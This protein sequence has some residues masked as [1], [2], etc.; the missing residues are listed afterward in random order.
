MLDSWSLRLN[1]CFPF[2]AQSR[3]AASSTTRDLPTEQYEEGYHYAGSGAFLDSCLQLMNSLHFSL[4][5]RNSTGMTREEVRD[6]KQNR[7]QQQ[8][9][10]K[11]TDQQTA[12]RKKKSQRIFKRQKISRE[13]LTE[14]RQ[15]NA[16]LTRKDLDDWAVTKSP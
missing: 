2:Q 15:E 7:K 4:P 13:S 11:D 16:V 8:T 10:D 5:S 12:G 1:F 9:H 6:E 14:Q 3:R